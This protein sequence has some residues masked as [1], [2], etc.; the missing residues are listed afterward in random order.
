MRRALVLAALLVAPALP[1]LAAEQVPCGTTLGAAR[2]CPDLVVDGTRLGESVVE[3]QTFDATHCAVLE[4][5]ASPGERRLLRFTF[6]S[7][8]VG[9]ADLVI[10]RP[11][12]HPDWFEWGAC[13]RHWHFREYADYRLWTTEAYP[14]W[15]AAR[16][17]HPGATAEEVLAAD[18][19]LREGFVAGHKQGFCVMDM[20]PP[21]P[22]LAP[23]Y[24][25]CADQGLSVGWADRY[26]MLLDG[27]WIDVTGLPPGYYVLE[28]EVNA[29]RLFEESDYANNAASNVVEVYVPE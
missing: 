29:E 4:G 25:D 9:L 8:N 20:V 5:A 21:L 16:A 15:L 13:H 23:R 6:T 27:Q 28:A 2:L 22:T 10:G 18:P 14:R 24:K 7:P 12:A 19:T 17:A 3:T 11:S 26:S 1:A